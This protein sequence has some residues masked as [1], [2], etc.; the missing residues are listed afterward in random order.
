MFAHNK[1]NILCV[2]QPLSSILA[3]TKIGAI[4]KTKL[5]E[6]GYIRFFFLNRANHLYR[7]VT[8]LHP[9]IIGLLPFSSRLRKTKTITSRTTPTATPRSTPGFAIVLTGP[10]PGGAMTTK[11]SCA[12][13]GASPTFSE[14]GVESTRRIKA[15]VGTGEAVRPFKM[16]GIGNCVGRIDR[17]HGRH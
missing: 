3:P 8:E 14:A 15:T 6:H 5:P 17:Y 11:V 2:E 10:A 1:T 4:Y 13:G 12:A 7:L 16:R 9:G